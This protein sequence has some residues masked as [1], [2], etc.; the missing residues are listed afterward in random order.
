MN[1]PFFLF[2]KSPSFFEQEADLRGKI[3]FKL[4]VI[5]TILLL[6]HFN[7]EPENISM[8]IYLQKTSY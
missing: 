7:T 2:S 8:H 5:E 4:H 1:Q 3:D 6:G